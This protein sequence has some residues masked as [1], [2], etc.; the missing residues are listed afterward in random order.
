V[1]VFPLQLTRWPEEAGCSPG[2]KSRAT[3]PT[4]KIEFV[5]FLALQKLLVEGY[6]SEQSRKILGLFSPPTGYDFQWKD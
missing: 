3:G 5:A 2:A 6:R 1:G 4:A